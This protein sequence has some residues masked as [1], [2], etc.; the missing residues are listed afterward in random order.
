[1]ADTIHHRIRR[2]L[3][4]VDKSQVDLAKAVGV[5]PQAV[6]QWLDHPTRKPK[7]PER[8]LVAKIA[9]FLETTESYLLRGETDM[10]VHKSSIIGVDTHQGTAVPFIPLDDLML[11]NSDSNSVIGRSRGSKVQTQHHV[12]SKAVAFALQDNSMEPRFSENDIIVID[13]EVNYGAGDYIA[14]HIKPLEINVF[15]QFVYDGPDHRMLKAVNG[16]HRSYRFSHEEWEEDVV[17]LGTWVERRE[18][19]QKSLKRHTP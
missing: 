19:N 16:D 7:G 9:E 14:V 1:M 18:V 6:N 3:K 13:P 15:R 2:R 10:L 11:I 8:E 4:E 5:S 17:V 12:S